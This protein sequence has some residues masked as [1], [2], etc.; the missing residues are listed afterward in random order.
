MHRTGFGRR[1]APCITVCLLNVL[2]FL[3][4]GRCMAVS[5]NAP[6]SQR[7]PAYGEGPLYIDELPPNLPAYSSVRGIG[8]KADLLHARAFSAMQRQAYRLDGLFAS[9]E[10]PRERVRTSRFRIGMFGEIVDSTD[11]TLRFDPEFDI[12]LHL[13]SAQ[14]RLN[15]FITTEGLDELPGMDPTD[16]VGALRIGLARAFG[17]YFEADTG[18]RLNWPP[19]VFVRAR[20]RTRW[21]AANWQLYPESSVF[22]QSDE[23]FG[24]KGAFSADRWSG[25][26]LFRTATGVKLTERSDGVE[27]DETLS[28]GYAFELLD[29]RKLGQRARGRDIARGGGVRYT[30]GGHDDGPFLIDEHRVTLFYRFPLRKRWLY[31]VIAP[32]VSFHNARDWE[33]EPGIKF[34][35]DMLCWGLGDR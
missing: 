6:V 4:A 32:E 17:R 5:T 1:A 21:N 14:R 20:W 11:V 24:T 25:R 27:W 12:K 2:A 29:E 30:I 16:R 13:P 15:L 9:D 7:P 22:W 34:G 31:G 18:A 8:A 28:I 19:E 10:E 33:A 35:L 26:S 23:G 3:V